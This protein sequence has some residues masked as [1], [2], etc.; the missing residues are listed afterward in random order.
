MAIDTDNVAAP[1]DPPSPWSV[2]YSIE[3]Y[4][5]HETKQVDKDP[6]WY[7]VVGKRV[8]RLVPLKVLGVG[9]V[10]VLLYIGASRIADGLVRGPNDQNV[11]LP[12]SFFGP[13]TASS[14]RQN[15]NSPGAQ[16]VSA[17]LDD[18]PATTWLEC[19]G[20]EP[21]RA[22]N[23][24]MKRG[25]CD[26]SP[27]NNVRR[28]I[29]ESILLPLTQPTDIKAVSIRNGR[30]PNQREF[31]R[32]G[33]VKLVRVEVWRKG[34]AN[35]QQATTELLDKTLSDEMGYQSF[36]LDC[37][38]G[39]LLIQVSQCKDVTQIRITIKDIYVGEKQ[40]EPKVV[41]GSP[42]V[43]SS[44]YKASTDTGLSDILLIPSQVAISFSELA[45]PLTG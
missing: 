37:E 43:D 45:K 18:D 34:T 9:I 8:A 4:V 12:A 44:L 7:E 25:T 24:R 31:Y 39:G 28:G 38:R 33:R 40:P 17:L 10:I 30:Q 11:P 6:F 42:K 29:G 26:Q 20:G 23:G 1:P 35:D 32:N 19:G 2:K 22:A 13:V 15:T 16:P 21:V 5:R 36:P 14:Y 27:D 3:K 41:E